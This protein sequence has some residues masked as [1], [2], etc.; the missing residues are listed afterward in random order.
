MKEVKKG[1]QAVKSDY[2]LVEGIIIGE[3]RKSK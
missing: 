3:R 1:N 2:D